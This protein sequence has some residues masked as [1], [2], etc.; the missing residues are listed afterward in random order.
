MENFILRTNA[1]PVYGFLSYINARTSKGESPPQGKILDCGA[2]GSL[3]P[4]A[5]FA[6]HGFEAY[7]IDLS[8]EQL[9]QAREFCERQGLDLH[10]RSGDMRHIPFEAETFDYVYEHY[11]MCHL[12]KADTARAIGE[13]Y[14]VLKPGGLCLLG[15]ISLDCWPTS[16][17]GQEGSPGEYWGEEG[18]ERRLHSLFSDEEMDDLLTDWEMVHKEKHLSYHRGVV[19]KPT[20]EAWMDAYNEIGSGY[21]RDAWG[22]RFVNRADEFQYSHL[23]YYLR[24]PG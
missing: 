3:P 17:F 2:G 4:L 15:A 1:I 13:M 14:R 9:S 20:M 6:R 11:S 16:V 12:S 18:G 21:S 10:L 19:E 22:A 24:K 8:D 23:Y 5:L 7:G